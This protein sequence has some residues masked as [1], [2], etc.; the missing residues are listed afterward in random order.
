MLLAAG[1]TQAADKTLDRTF[2]V[3]PGGTLTVEADAGEVRV[4]ASDGNQVVVHMVFH[5]SEKELAKTI[6]DAVQ[7]DNGVTV[8]M[9]K[10]SHNWFSF[11][12]GDSSAD[13]LIEVTVPRNYLVN[14]RTGGGSVELRDTVG[15]ASLHTSGG[16]ISA[17]NV[18]GNIELRT[19][20][21]SIQADSIKGDVDADT[22]GGDVRVER[23]DGKIKANTSGGSVRV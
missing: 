10:D 3:S 20:G 11:S 16:D 2:P 1:S 6:L 9:K 14:A 18:T 5:G 17:K 4:K 7:K 21:G 8:T 19:S 23:I 12:W 22:S 15:A 13:E